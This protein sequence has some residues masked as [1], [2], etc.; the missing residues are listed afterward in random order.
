VSQDAL[1]RL[2]VEFGELTNVMGS[3]ASLIVRDHVRA[4]GESMKEFPQ[5]RLTTL[6]ESLSKEISDEKLKADFCERFAKM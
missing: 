4:L 2:I 3:V 1:N 5:A 6:L